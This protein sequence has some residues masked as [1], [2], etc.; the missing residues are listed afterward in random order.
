[1]QSPVSTL[2]SIRYRNGKLDLL[3][4]RKLPLVSEYE[5]VNNAEDGWEAIRSMKV[6]GAP[7]IAIAGALSLA[8]EA[9]RILAAT[10]FA[11]GD[12]AAAADYLVNKLEYLK[13]S[14]PTAVNLFEAADRLTRLARD[15]AATAAAGQEGAR[16]VFQAYIAE[17]EK[18]LEDD[19]AAN[20]AMG[21]HGADHIL[22]LQSK[23]GSNV[24]VITH[25]NTGSLATAGYGTALGVIRALNE[26][27]KLERAFCTETRPYNQGA[28]L[29]AYELVAE[30]IPGTLVTDSMVAAL[31][32]SPNK[33]HAVIV[34]A[35]RIAANGD[36]ANKIGTY[37]LAIAAKY[38]KVPFFVAAPLTTI[39][40]EM[41]NGSG[42]KIE[43]RP[44]DEL[45]NVNGMRIAAP[46]IGVWN[47]S[48][49]VT[50]G[51]LIDGIITELGV[52]QKGADGQFHV[53]HFIKDK[54]SSQ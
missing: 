19:I 15:K 46:G 10:E 51:E 53:A 31:M 38:H 52:I 40:L 26:S 48:F 29:T 6:R 14:R 36:T 39:D 43:E 42:I 44:A 2:E 21:K 3:E 49:D 9:H 20:K 18:M 25:C 24:R 54:S 12:A 41:E 11:F 35:D 4:Q 5:E 37:Q 13:T 7:A 33:P 45:T 47:P 32:N 17:A 23:D 34:G 1:M 27:G 22:A 50:P 16:Q 30:Q 8:V 28:R